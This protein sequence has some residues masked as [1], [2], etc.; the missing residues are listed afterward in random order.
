[1]KR[2]IVAIAAVGL[3]AIGLATAPAAVASGT[4]TGTITGTTGPLIVPPGATCELDG[5]TVNGS[6]TVQT[7]ATLEVYGSTHI[8]GAVTAN[9]AREIHIFGLQSVMNRIDGSLTING[10]SSNAKDSEICSVTIGGSV[11]VY[12]V[13]EPSDELSIDG[14]GSENDCYGVGTTVSSPNGPVII[15]GSVTFD[16]NPEEVELSHASVSGSVNVLSNSDGD[17]VLDDGHAG[18]AEIEGNK[19]GGTL[20]CSG[21]VN[22]IDNGGELNTATTKTGQCVGK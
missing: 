22:G 4:C 9:S 2:L 8:T 13:D 5:A 14:D 12:R 11:A 3:A 17:T 10:S 15:K 18:S 16:H 21:N 6:V 1:M 19:I 7:D 20:A